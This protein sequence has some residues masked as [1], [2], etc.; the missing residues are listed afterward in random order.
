MGKHM[1]GD[2]YLLNGNVEVHLDQLTVMVAG[3]EE[4]LEAKTIE[5]LAYFI[6]HPNTVLSANQIIDAVWRGAIVSDN[7]VHKRIAILRKAFGDDSRQP[8]FIQTV[9]KKGYRFIADIQPLKTDN[10]AEKAGPATTQHV[11]PPPVA[12]SVSKKPTQGLYAGLLA[13]L[14]LVLILVW[15]NTRDQVP[16]KHFLIALETDNQVQDVSIIETQMMLKSAIAQLPR[17][18]T[19][20]T[21]DPSIASLDNTPELAAL[22][23]THILNTDFTYNDAEIT[24]DVTFRDIEGAAATLQLSVPQKQRS[25]AEMVHQIAQRIADYLN[26]DTPAESAPID[27]NDNNLAIL[28]ARLTLKHNRVEAFPQTIATLESQLKLHPDDLATMDVLSELYLAY[29]VSKLTVSNTYDEKAQHLSD[30]MIDAYPTAYQGYRQRAKLYIHRGD[31][32]AA[33]QAL[34]QAI[35]RTEGDYQVLYPDMTNT[36][37]RLGNLVQALEYARRAYVYDPLSYSALSKYITLLSDNGKF[38][39]AEAILND[40]LALS[41]TSS[42]LK[43]LKSQLYFEFGQ[44]HQ[45][46]SLLASVPDNQPRDTIRI[47]IRR[48]LVECKWSAGEQGLL[49]LK[50]MPLPVQNDIFHI[51]ATNY[52]LSTVDPFAPL[53]THTEKGFIKAAESTIKGSQAYNIVTAWRAL[54]LFFDGDYAQASDIL[55]SLG[56]DDQNIRMRPTH[57]V[58]FAAYALL[59]L[60]K[61]QHPTSHDYAAR[62]LAK[63]EHLIREHASGP[64]F[65][66]A[67]TEY[68]IVSGD[69]NKAENQ[70]RQAILNG[71]NWM[72]WETNSPVLSQ[73][74]VKARLQRFLED[75]DVIRL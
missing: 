44:P 41:P 53:L 45:A 23:I 62:T 51:A 60:K 64:D 52:C 25:Q 63:V 18:T 69:W 19:T 59:A 38:S 24:I 7:V 65:H 57:D 71:L 6:E 29:S 67:A 3:Q 8:S 5:V 20:S 26:I 36:S 2:D 66:L 12:D 15:L 21:N 33:M 4:K 40:Q 68:F 73:P 50:S 1:S 56:L 11:T 46:L 35:E 47:D 54:A 58:R 16:Q 17:V 55:L 10:V 30:R 37:Y 49:R 34:S 42:L 22:G 14:G 9:P 32:Q 28:R 13:V 72:T 70:F 75:I 48:A 27:N 61:H 31:H 43:F 74:D 39:Q